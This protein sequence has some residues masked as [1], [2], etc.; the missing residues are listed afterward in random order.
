LD[1][2]GPASCISSTRCRTLRLSDFGTV[3]FGRASTTDGDGR[4]GSIASSA[5]STTKIALGQSTEN[6]RF[7]G[8]FG[9]GAGAT[10]A[11]LSSRGASFSVSFE[12]QPVTQ[13][14]G[15]PATFPS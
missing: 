15:P 8:S 13:G 6:A 9:A 14:G 3:G 12:A 5:W 11:A 10:P 1:R 7:P 2:G 4:S